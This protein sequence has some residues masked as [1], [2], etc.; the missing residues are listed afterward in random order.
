MAQGEP[1]TVL[2]WRERRFLPPKVS[3]VERGFRDPPP[4]TSHRT[5][6]IPGLEGSPGRRQLSVYVSASP[7]SPAALRGQGAG[8]VHLPLPRAHPVRGKLFSLW[9]EHRGSVIAAPVRPSVFSP[10]APGASSAHY[11]PSVS[12]LV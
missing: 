6:F 5:L 9:K 11:V 1:R 12:F 3:F 7:I 8:F 4:L 2:G 10:A